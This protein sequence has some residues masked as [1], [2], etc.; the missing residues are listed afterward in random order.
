MSETHVDAAKLLRDLGSRDAAIRLKASKQLESE[1]RKAATKQRQLQ[2][3]NREVTALFIAA[4]DDSD[5]KVVHNGVVA[6]AQISRHY[7]K[8]DR[9][10]PKL[11]GLVHSEHPL[12]TRWVIDALVQLRGE[13]SLDDVLPLCADPSAEARAMVFDHLYS[14]LVALRTARSGP[15]RPENQKRMRAAAVRGLGDNDRTV[16][17][18]AAA[19]LG[20][21]GDST[22]L[23]ALRKALKQESYWLTEQTIANAIKGLEERQGERGRESLSATEKDSRPHF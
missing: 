3:G 5:P 20:V 22:V 11:L 16:R 14:W 23:P 4:L 13:A 2:F 18:N 1:L 15:I 8:D 7:F 9:A 17:G 10:Y 6:L 21:V 12:T 19:L